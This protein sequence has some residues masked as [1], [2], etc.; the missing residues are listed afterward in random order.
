MSVCTVVSLLPLTLAAVTRFLTQSDHDY[1]EHVTSPLQPPGW[2]FGIVW[3]VIYI[4]Y[5]MLLCRFIF[6][7]EPHTRILLGMYAFN[8]ALNLAWTPVVFT[9]DK[10]VVGLY[11]IY[12]KIMI[13]VFMML[14][15][16]D[17]I[18]RLL[19]TPYIAWL[20]V[21]RSLQIDLIQQRKSDS[22]SSK[23]ITCESSDNDIIR[24]TF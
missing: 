1:C 9:H 4:L 16:V 17:T 6:L 13:L 3:T 7:N 11:I 10:K 8:F 15:S 20:L 2:V 5:G 14:M 24:S 18:N 19:M 22:S 23:Y 12:T 21:A